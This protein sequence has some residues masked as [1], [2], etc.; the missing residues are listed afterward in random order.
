MF[1]W[2][3]KTQYIPLFQNTMTWPQYPRAFLF[4]LGIQSYQKNL[5][6]QLIVGKFSYQFKENNLLHYKPQTFRF[7]IFLGRTTALF[8]DT[9]CFTLSG[10]K[11]LLCYPLWKYRQFIDKKKPTWLRETLNDCSSHCFTSLCFFPQN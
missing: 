5:H 9:C 11:P 4:L 2:N 8:S 7:F 1:Q 3:I 6:K 10:S